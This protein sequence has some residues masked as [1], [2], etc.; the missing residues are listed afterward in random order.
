MAYAAILGQTGSSGILPQITIKPIRYTYTSVVLQNN[1]TSKQFT[2]TYDGSNW[3]AQVDEYGT[4]TITGTYSG[5]TKTA[6]LDVEVNQEYSVTLGYTPVPTLNDN[7][8]ATISYASDNNLGESLWSVGDAKYTKVNGAIG[9]GLNLSNEGFWVYILGFNHN[10]TLE[11]TGIT[12][13]WY[14][15]ASTTSSLNG[16]LIDSNYDNNM[17][18]GTWFNMNNFTTNSGGWEQSRMRTVLIP[19]FKNCLESEL[20]SILKTV[21][22][23]TD[24]VGNNTGNVQSNVTA[25][26]DDIFLLSEFEI[27]GSISYSNTYEQNYQKQYQYYIDGNSKI[28]YRYNTSYKAYWWLRSPD[29]NSQSEFCNVATDGEKSSEYAHRSCGFAPAFVV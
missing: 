13:G 27:F 14:R 3:V 4:Y 11:G 8:W 28:K 24:N 25:T 29:N 18:T 15:T 5:G 2:A 1:E 12:F 26:Q 20:V 6:T 7:D 22:K 10:S 17:T 9:N 21:S 16:A 19:Q 23:Y